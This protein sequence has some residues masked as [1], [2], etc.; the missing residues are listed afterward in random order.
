M[1]LILASG[2]SSCDDSWTKHFDDVKSVRK[3]NMDL[4]GWV[5]PFIPQ[6]ATNITATGDLDSSRAFGSFLS[7]DAESVR[8]A[9]STAN[10]SYPVPD[11]AT[12]WLGLGN[13]GDT[14]AGKLR[15]KGIEVLDCRAQKFTLAYSISKNQF[16]YWTVPR[17]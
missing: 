13:L 10:N 15:G 8:E 17:N 4:K 9:C 14:N 16:Y 5:P 3:E 12:R 6:D 1:I 2:A 11:Y 7:M